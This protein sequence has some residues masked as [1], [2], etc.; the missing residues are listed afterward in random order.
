MIKKYWVHPCN[1]STEKELE[2][3]IR[4]S[5]G[6]RN[7][8]RDNLDMV[9]KLSELKKKIEKFEKLMKEKNCPDD[10]DLDKVIFKEYF[11]DSFFDVEMDDWQQFKKELLGEE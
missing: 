6:R 4:K 3:Y 8:V 5:K 10:I 2:E 11:N 1:L 7:K 9:V